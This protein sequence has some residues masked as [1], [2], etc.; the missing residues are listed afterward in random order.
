M[1]ACLFH[2]VLMDKP[3]AVLIALFEAKEAAYASNLAKAVDCTYPHI[4]KIISE[5]RKA[6][7]I[8]VSAKGRIKPINLTPLGKKIARKLKELKEACMAE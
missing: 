8:E 4:A 2:L 3:A 6:G 1:K 7:L 5:F